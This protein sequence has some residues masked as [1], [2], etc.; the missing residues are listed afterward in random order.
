MSKY[1]INTWG[2]LYKS[3]RNAGFKAPGDADEIYRCNGFRI[4]RLP[5]LAWLDRLG[6]GKIIRWI[7]VG[8]LAFRFRAS[9]EVHVQ[10]T[11]S[12][13]VARIVRS[14]RKRGRRIVL[15][16]HDISF[17][18]YGTDAAGEIALYNSADELIVHTRAMA[19]E[20]HRRGV[21]A[22]MRVLT[23]FDYLS[24]AR[25]FYREPDIRSVV[26]AGNLIKSAFLPGFIVE[27]SSHNV[28]IYLYGSACP[29]IPAGH[30]RLSYEGSFSPDDISAIK[31]AWGL[32]WDGAT[33]D[34]CDPYLIYNAPHKLSLYLAAEK[35]LIVWRR[36][37]L[38]DF[39]SA[40]G[41]GIAVDSLSEI[42][43]LLSQVTPEMYGDYAARV[44][45][46]GAKVRQGLFLGEILRQL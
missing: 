28:S 24:D 36:S 35:P 25:E 20:L 31:G 46:A 27:A 43:A 39:V 44:A 13:M 12:R 3:R 7:Y 34:D 18:R 5:S 33:A 45:E 41:L 1:A 19:D 9:D 4:I 6:V 32:V 42:P 15:L 22:P 2:D 38:H 23:L 40:N 29:A 14:L 21:R 26:F 17:L 11:G 30:P 16:V 37:A 8:C 10:L